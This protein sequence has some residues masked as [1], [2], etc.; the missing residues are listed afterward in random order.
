MY[1]DEVRGMVRRGR[2]LRVDDGAGQQL[3]DVRGLASETMTRVYRA[4]GYGLTAN[5]PTGAEGFL[6]SLGGRADRAMALGFEAPGARPTGLAPG[7]TALYGPTGSILRLYTDKVRIDAGGK[8]VEIVNAT[9]VTV[10][11]STE[12]VFKVGSRFNR[13]RANR[14]DLAVKS[15]TEEA[16]P[17][18]VTTA[19]PSAVVYARID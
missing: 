14:I 3:V 11:A 9:K 1:D 4:Q 10:E 6:L 2:I 8:P 17:Q 18:V 19:G 7:E 12:I 16:G 5:P 15:A 13:F